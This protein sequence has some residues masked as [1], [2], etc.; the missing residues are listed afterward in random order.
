MGDI[1]ITKNENLSEIKIE[2][3]N[4]GDYF[5]RISDKNNSITQPF[6]KK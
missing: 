1:L 6:I 4:S 2:Q 3:L 5:I